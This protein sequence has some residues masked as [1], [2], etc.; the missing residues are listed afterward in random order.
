M[1]DPYRR[2]RLLQGSNRINN[3]LTGR[4]RGRPEAPRTPEQIR[5]DQVSRAFARAFDQLQPNLD[6]GRRAQLVNLGVNLDPNSVQGK[7]IEIL[8]TALVLSSGSLGSDRLTPNTY[9]GLLRQIVP[10]ASNGFADE[11]LLYIAYLQESQPNGYLLPAL[12]DWTDTW[13]P[14]DLVEVDLS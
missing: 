2:Q 9:P 4:G 11:V 3:N 1:S 12:P 10:N 5:Y 7:N 8:A 14:V 6:P 13:L